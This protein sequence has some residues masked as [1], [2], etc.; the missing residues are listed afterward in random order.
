[1]S[2]NIVN[3]PKNNGWLKLTPTNVEPLKKLGYEVMQDNNGLFWY[4][5]K[6]DKIQESTITNVLL[7]QPGDGWIKTAERN[8][9]RLK[10]TGKYDVEK[11]SDGKWYYKL[12]S[13]T[14]T[15]DPITTS[16]TTTTTV[17]PNPTPDPDIVPD[18][19]KIFW[20]KIK[21]EKLLEK[22]KG[23]GKKVW[24]QGGVWYRD[25]R[26]RLSNWWEDM[27]TLPDWAEKQP[28]ISD[29]GGV[30]RSDS[31][32]KVQVRTQD[33]E[34]YLYFY[35]D[36]KFVYENA[37]KAILNGTW[38]CVSGKLYIKTED[39]YEYTKEF[40]WDNTGKSN[41]GSLSS[42]NTSSGNKKIY[43]TPGD[44]YQYRLSD[45]CEWETKGKSITDWKSLKNL[46][47]AIRK[48]DKRFPEAKK[49]CSQSTNT[50]PLPPPTPP[51]TTESSK[52]SWTNDYPCIS[53][54]GKMIPTTQTNKIS[55]PTTS[56]NDSINFYKNLKFIY[57]F[58]DGS[59]INGT[60]K[61]ENGEMVIDTEDGGRYTSSKGWTKVN[62]IK[63]D[64][65]NPNVSDDSEL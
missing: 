36:G 47:N 40:G 2:D 30:D 15:P 43:S 16:T 26:D 20:E 19:A 4:K 41:L 28:C 24:Q 52:P 35:K 63:P 50:T 61:C 37:V 49:E 46:P 64:E 22:L 21:D 3:S 31:D 18:I 39:G 65:F 8:V 9:T 44:P 23:A 25:I 53:G 6:S 1:M 34:D 32:D 56:G 55:F 54:F 12:K 48:L 42:S 38:K 5:P 45:D 14:P 62:Q 57:E 58:E 17:N 7:E 33:G 11:G 51:T 59:I 10:A 13:S 29:V 27:T 60:W